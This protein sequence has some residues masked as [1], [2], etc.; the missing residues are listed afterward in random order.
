MPG[1]AG[2][3]TLCVSGDRYVDHEAQVGALLAID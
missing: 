1:A 3:L 2:T